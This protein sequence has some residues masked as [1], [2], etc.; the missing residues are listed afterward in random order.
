MET[1]PTRKEALIAE[2]GISSTTLA[3]R[4]ELLYKQNP[5]NTNRTIEFIISHLRSG[6]VSS[7]RALA[8]TDGDKIHDALGKYREVEALLKKELFRGEENHPWSLLD[9]LAAA[10]EDEEQG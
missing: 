3:E 1:E 5:E 8:F 2:G 6:D 7:A 10:R 4:I 9:E